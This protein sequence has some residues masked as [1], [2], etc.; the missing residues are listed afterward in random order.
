MTMEKAMI[1]II[2]ASKSQKGW[3]IGEA[4]NVTKLPA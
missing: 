4:C 3:Q 1:P 2:E